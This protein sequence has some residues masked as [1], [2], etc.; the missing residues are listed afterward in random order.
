MI[1]LSPPPI[2]SP[3]LDAAGMLTAPWV[4]W[5]RQLYERIGGAN[6][7]DINSLALLASDTARHEGA[8]LLAEIDA[9]RMAA[10][11]GD[12]E[13]IRA[14]IDSVDAHLSGTMLFSSE[15]AEIRAALD[16]VMT[17]PVQVD[18]SD[19]LIGLRKRLD[20]IESVV[21]V[22]RAPDSVAITSGGWVDV[23]T[24]GGR[25]LQVVDTAAAV[26]F[27][28]MTGGASGVGPAI[29][30][31]GDANNIDLNIW[32]KGAGSVYIRSALLDGNARI[33][34]WASATTATVNGYVT[35]KDTTG[36][37]RKLATI[38]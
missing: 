32:P 23:V 14:R 11:A 28:A 5:F 20:A 31:A 22:S 13:S 38:A 35:I 9:A 12:V 25:Q 8:E 16:G 2:R 15:I 21:V 19:E 7:T 24:P 36:A 17:A 34:S 1:T 27:V 33:G 37:A 30:S 6:A 29:G 4:Q 3:V 10:L 18:R 26:N